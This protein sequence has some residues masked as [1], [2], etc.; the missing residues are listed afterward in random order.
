MQYWCGKEKT[1]PSRAETNV[2]R[3]EQVE[4]VSIQ[5]VGILRE[6]HPHSVS[7]TWIK[8]LVRTHTIHTRRQTLPASSQACWLRSNNNTGECWAYS[9]KSR[10]YTHNRGAGQR[11][12]KLIVLA[13]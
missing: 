11:R 5:I 10:Q 2:V 12:D 3:K 13:P 9:G 7:V 8:Y 6:T 1:N 4:L